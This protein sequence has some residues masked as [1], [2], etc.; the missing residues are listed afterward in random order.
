MEDFAKKKSDWPKMEKKKFYPR[1]AK[2]KKIFPARRL[3]KKN[4]PKDKKNPIT[5]VW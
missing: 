3:E 5:E 1:G 4:N 2:K